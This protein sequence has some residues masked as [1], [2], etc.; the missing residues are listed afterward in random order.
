MDIDASTLRAISISLIIRFFF[1]VFDQDRI[2]RVYLTRRSSS[3]RD[4]TIW[5][6]RE[7]VCAHSDSCCKDIGLEDQRA[8]QSH[9]FNAHNLSIELIS[10]LIS[11]ESSNVFRVLLPD[12]TKAVSAIK[13]DESARSFIARLSGDSFR[14]P[15]P[16][17]ELQGTMKRASSIKTDPYVEV[18]DEAPRGRSKVADGQQT[19]VWWRN[20]G[21]IM[22][23]YLTPEQISVIEGDGKRPI[24][25]VADEL[26]KYL[27]AMPSRPTNSLE[28][29]LSYIVNQYKEAWAETTHFLSLEGRDGL[30]R[31]QDIRWDTDRNSYK[32]PFKNTKGK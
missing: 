6:S 27:K 16:S 7:T 2:K 13:D 5:R 4:I 21:A 3:C 23:V 28:K 18:L 29:E 14:K 26:K 9:L 32:I 25:A 17:Y 1:Y 11:F 8:F 15:P 31:T 30:Y 22:Q 19:E 20:I 10:F 24:L 12:L